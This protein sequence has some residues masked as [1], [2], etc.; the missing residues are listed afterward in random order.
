MTNFASLLWRV[1]MDYEEA[2][3]IYRLALD[4]YPN[5]PRATLRFAAFLLA[6][7]RFAEAADQAR[8]TLAL[9]GAQ[10]NADRHDFVAESLLYLGLVKRIDGMDDSA[11]LERLK[12]LLSVGFPRYSA[13][14]DDILKATLE[15]LQ[16]EDRQL[17]TTL[18]DAVLNGKRVR[19]L[20]R[21]LRWKAL[22]AVPPVL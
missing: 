3:R 19:D 11:E 20:D 21:H 8:K 17:Y 1:R 7:G 6:R 15:R 18:A 9:C 10:A 4:I 2:E 5:Y 14:F 22:P 13:P 16:D 12:I